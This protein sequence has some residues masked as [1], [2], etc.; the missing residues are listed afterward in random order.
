MLQA[1]LVQM[2]LV[3][4]AGNNNT[5]VLIKNLFHHIDDVAVIAVV[6]D[7]QMHGGIHLVAAVYIGFF[8]IKF[9][10][11]VQQFFGRNV[12]PGQLQ[13]DWFNLHTG[14]IGRASCRERV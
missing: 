11:P 1:G 13:R 6:D 9:L 8:G 10:F 4:G 14:Q 3:L 2:G 12:R 7:R 5:G